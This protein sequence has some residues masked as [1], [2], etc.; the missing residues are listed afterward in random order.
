MK[1]IIL[2]TIFALYHT[3][4]C[5]QV[6]HVLNTSF[7][8]FSSCPFMVD[9]IT[10][11]DH[12]SSIDTS[13][14]AS[15]CTPQY[16]NACSVN[17]GVPLGLGNYQNAKTGAAFVSIGMSIVDSTTSTIYDG[18]EYLQGRLSNILKQDSSYCVKY[19]IIS[20]DSSYLRCNNQGV[21]F[22]DGSV[23]AVQSDCLYPLDN[24]LPQIENHS[25]I[26]DNNNWQKLESIL[27]AN[28]T[29]SYLTFGNFKS[30]LFTNY[31]TVNTNTSFYSSATYLI[32]DVSVIEYNLPAFAGTDA[33]IANGDSVYL[34]RPNE[35]G[36]E[37]RWWA[38]GIAMNDSS[39][40]F[41]AKPTQTT[42]Y[43]LQQKICGNTKYDTVNVTVSG[44]SSIRNT[45]QVATFNLYP[46]PSTGTFTMTAS[47][48]EV[49]TFEITTVTGQLVLKDRFRNTIQLDA[50][51]QLAKGIYLCKVSQNGNVEY[52]GKIV[53]Q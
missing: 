33:L 1:K 2:L 35:I 38:N 8:D 4:L 49:A 28:G 41:W 32:E 34:G 13:G 5:A 36:P 42:Q 30:Y 53:V 6:N 40:G 22:D 44:L 23:D 48:N 12:W 10:F 3:L 51:N 39:L 14:N 26:I 47:N 15:L 9:Q 17:M 50:S 16:Y 31:S 27:V 24:I 11:A 46:N 21:Y 25:I 20:V 45:H 37:C 19:F 18:R 52:Q 7:E 43:V 29:E